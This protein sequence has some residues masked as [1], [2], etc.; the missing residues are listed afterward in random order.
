M[1]ESEIPSIP[2]AAATVLS[3]CPQ[4]NAEL[5]VLRIIPGRSSEYWTLRCTRCGGIHLDIVKPRARVI[6]PDNPQLD[7]SLSP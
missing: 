7:D 4:C 2:S 1:P 3:N 5:A 6:Q